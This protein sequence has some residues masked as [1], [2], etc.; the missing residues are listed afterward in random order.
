MNVHFSYKVNKT[1]DLEKEINQQVEKIRRRL[2]VFRPE[3]IH[4]KGIVE[5]NSVREGFLV[6][7]NL[8]LPSGQMAAQERSPNA[9]TA[10]KGAFDGLVEQ[11]TKHKDHLRNTHRWPRWRRVG[12]TRPQPQVPFEETVAAVQPPTVSS[13]DISSYVN[14]NLGR[15]QRF[16]E[17]ELRYRESIDQLAP[18]TLTPAEIINEA[19][20]NALGDGLDKPERLALEPWLY[21]LS[22]R[23]IDDLS[24]RTGEDPGSVPLQRNQRA[25]NVR[26]SDEPQ[27]QYHQPDEQLIAQDTIPDRGTATPEDIAASDEMITLVEAALLSAPRENREAFIL[28][29]IEGFTVEEIAAI[30]DRKPEQVRVSVNS[31]R[32]H[33]RKALPIPNEF[34][35]K[36]LQHSRTA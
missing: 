26:A 28:N 12:R 15:L 7:L 18:E 29:A 2:Q 36:L 24:S 31:A 25:P 35:D 23:A 8:R 5:Q 27:L 1:P 14:A 11:L 16:V 32:D 13:E 34:R 6:S 21:R 33:L 17:R 20:A 9:T 30:T 22:M 3:L 19:V 10:I 4:L